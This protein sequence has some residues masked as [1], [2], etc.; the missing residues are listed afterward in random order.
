[1]ENTRVSIREEIHD[2]IQNTTSPNVFLLLGAAGTGKSTISTTIAEEYTR[3]NSLGCHLFF[4]R[5]KSDPATVIRTIACSLAEYNQNIAECIEDALKYKVGLTSATLDIQFDTFLSTPLHQSRTNSKP[6]LIILDA[7]DECGSHQTRAT[8]IRVLR[9]KLPS[10]PPN[11]RFLITGRPES[12]IHRFHNFRKFKVVQL[13]EYNG[14]GDVKKYIDTNLIELQQEEMVSFEDEKEMERMGSALGEAANGLFIW[15]S[16]AI[17]MVKDKKGDCQSTLEELVST[18][19]LSLNHLYSVAL[20]NAFDWDAR[21]KKLFRDV[22]GLI[23]FGKE[24]MRDEVI[25]GILGMEKG[26]T[27]RMLSC[28]RALV[29]YQRGEPIRLYHTSFYDYLTNIN[30]SSEPWYIDEIESKRKIAEQC[31]VGMDRMLHFNMCHLES[32][33]VANRDVVDLEERVQNYISSSLQYICCH[34]S[35]H[36]LDIPYSGGMQGALRAF[37]YNHLLF[38]LEVM[39]VTNTLDTH[40]GSILTHAISW[41]GVSLS[42]YTPTYFN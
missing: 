37:A 4:L 28:L 11:Y 5:G 25:D 38:W 24:Q 15:A 21:M 33:Y 31:F 30:T 41:I 1:M 18:K 12:D 32:S 22:F 20:H 9:D 2:W 6:I 8:L 29:I 26:S 36:L 3:D 40:G 27:G 16:T 17:Q 23:L 13:E 35:N 19:S 42:N 39:S 10:L 14:K 34:W 7:L